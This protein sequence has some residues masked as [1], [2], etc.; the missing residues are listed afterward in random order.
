[1]RPRRQP[2]LDLRLNAAAPD[3]AARWHEG[4]SV[5]Y[6]GGTLRLML[7]GE[8][9]EATQVSGALHLP[10]PPQAMPRQIQDCAEA[11]LRAEAVRHLTRLINEK[12]VLATRRTPRLALSFASRDHWIEAPDANTLRCHRRLI[13]QPPAIIDSAIGRE[14]A[15]LTNTTAATADCDLFALPSC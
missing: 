10:L 5:A 9:A 12:L 6:L 15:S 14:L 13:E 7:S 11:W 4:A 1:M 3:A 8:Y 2:Q